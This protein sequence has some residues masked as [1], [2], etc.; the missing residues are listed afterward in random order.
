MLTSCRYWR[1]P[2]RA[3]PANLAKQGIALLAFHCQKKKQFRKTILIMISPCLGLFIRFELMVDVQKVFHSGDLQSP[4]KKKG[5]LCQH[6]SE[7]QADP[8]SV[9]YQ[10]WS[11]WLDP[12]VKWNTSKNNKGVVNSAVHL[13]EPRCLIY[14]KNQFEPAHVH[15]RFVEQPS[16]F[17]SGSS[18]TGRENGDVP[19][20]QVLH[21]WV[22][23]A[24]PRGSVC[25]RKTM[26]STWPSPLLM[27]WVTSKFYGTVLQLL[28]DIKIKGERCVRFNRFTIETIISLG[29]S[30]SAL[31]NSGNSVFV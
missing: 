17:S 12:S 11:F 18:K 14:I 21:I 19:V 24:V 27:S 6:C 25:W 31:K 10:R 7:V 1:L 4:E 26:D 3:I 20:L 30:S 23:C 16:V 5:S 2:L 13:T 22:V 9:Q 15:R 29:P 28:F 8:S